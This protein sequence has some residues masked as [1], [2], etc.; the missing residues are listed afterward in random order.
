MSENLDLPEMRY[1]YAKSTVT[2]N[3]NDH[4]VI[5]GDGMIIMVISSR[6]LFI[7]M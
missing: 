5:S 4:I 6:L 7:W 1:A 3:G 2:I